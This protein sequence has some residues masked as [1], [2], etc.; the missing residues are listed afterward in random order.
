MS[1]YFFA[2][3][4]YHRGQ[5]AAQRSDMTVSVLCR[6]RIAEAKCVLD[7]GCGAGQTL[8]VVEGLNPTASLIG[9]D[10]DEEACRAG[11]G[12]NGRIFFIQ[13]EGE[14]LPIADGSVDFAICRVALNYMHQAT[15]LHELARVLA[16][17][18][19]LVL[20]FIS[21]GYTLRQ[22]LHPARGGVGQALG[23]FKDLLAGIALQVLGSQGRR[24]AFWGRSV[25]YTSC[26]WLR[27]RLRKDACEIAWLGCEGYYLG[28]AT[29]WWAIISRTK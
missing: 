23:N 4:T 7:V 28:C 18:G 6:A 29:I 20:S 3:S 14:H 9:V 8:R 13:A 16:P 27:R 22:A 12:E 19:K 17:G 11:Q 10:P 25:P 26:D 5:L 21:F 15:A 1:T 24:P 2:S